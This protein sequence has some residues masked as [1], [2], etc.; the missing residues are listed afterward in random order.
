MRKGENE[1]LLFEILN[2][3]FP[4]KWVSEYKGIS[5][6][7]FRF[8]AA[9]PTDKVCVEVDGGVWIHGRHN[10]PIGMQ[11]DLEKYNLAVLEGW[12]VLR[13]TPET[14]KRTPW[15]LIRDVRMLCGVAEDAAQTKL[16]LD[17]LKQA[18]IEQMQ[19]KLI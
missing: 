7:K 9:N 14:L 19:V 11:K 18:K 16:S 12:R 15:K 4:G 5:G 2:D 3:A 1:R 10:R 17:G 6:R 8:D 13:Y